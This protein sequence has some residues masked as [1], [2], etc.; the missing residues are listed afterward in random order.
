MAEINDEILIQR[1]LR[2]DQF[3]FAQIVEKYKQTAFSIAYQIT[4]NREDAE[5]IA[6]DAFVKAYQALK[7][8]KFES[9]FSTW[10][11]R[12]VY[13]TAISKKRKKKMEFVAIDHH[14]IEN[15]SED[16][17]VAGLQ[18]LDTDEQLKLV[19][20]VLKSLPGDDAA[21]I[22]LFYNQ[23]LNIE[24]ISH[25]TSLSVSNV[26]VKLHRIRKR[27]FAGVQLL[28]NQSTSTYEYKNSKS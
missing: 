27:I 22:N 20:H 3:A 6:M 2:G 10:L 4:G 8:F 21:L 9:K 5:E 15:Y 18:M 17:F 23:Q 11:Y 26:K 19:Q 24:E 12:I 25:I 1:T 16:N 28:L 14:L 7:G 13:N